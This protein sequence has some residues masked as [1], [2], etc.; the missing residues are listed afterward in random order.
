MNEHTPSPRPRTLDELLDHLMQ[1]RGAEH[2]PHLQE[3][4]RKA[5]QDF[6]ATLES[7]DLQR[8]AEARQKVHDTFAKTGITLKPHE[9]RS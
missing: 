8:R 1:L 6:A 7:D 3:D 4:A 2:A 5:L 9:P